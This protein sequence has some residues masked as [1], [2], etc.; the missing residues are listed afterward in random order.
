MTN[1]FEQ[2]YRRQKHFLTEILGLREYDT[3]TKEYLLCL[4][5]EI[6][7]VY[8]AAKLKQSKPVLSAAEREHV[9]EELVDCLKYL[10]NLGIVNYFS[11]EDM[12]RK[13]HEK[14]ASTELRAKTEK[15]CEDLYLNPT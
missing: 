12:I 2:M 9:L 4:Q 13:F 15:W 6:S 8:D 10:F 14:S 3:L 11:A 5:V 1:S 7:E